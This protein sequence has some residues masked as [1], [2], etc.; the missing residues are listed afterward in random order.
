VEGE[1][2]GRAFQDGFIATPGVV[3]SKELGFTPALS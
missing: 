1:K 3:Y 2:M